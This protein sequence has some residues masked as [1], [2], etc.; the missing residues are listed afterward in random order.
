M[1]THYEKLTSCLIRSK[2]R[3]RMD[4]YSLQRLDIDSL[5]QVIAD[6]VHNGKLICRDR[7]YKVIMIGASGVGKTSLVWRFVRDRF[8]ETSSSTIGAAFCAKSID[9]AA[10]KI[11]LDIWDTAGQERYDSLVPM[12]YRDA[13]IIFI[14]FDLTDTN[15][16]DRAIR[17][18]GDLEYGGAA[19]VSSIRNVNLILIGNKADCENSSHQDSRAKKFCE[20]HNAKTGD[21]EDKTIDGKKNLHFLHYV[22]TSAKQSV[23]VTETFCGAIAHIIDLEV[24]GSMDET[25]VNDDGLNLMSESSSGWGCGTFL[26]SINPMRLVWNPPI[27]DRD[28]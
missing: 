9:S 24:P 27:K 21:G 3:S 11:T 17:W 13:Q 18:I 5:K 26:S 8:D 1:S 16:L 2:P 10:G 7:R 19:S 28:R 20:E 4:E 6:K 14:V 12:Y 25:L 15:S 22:T 23:N